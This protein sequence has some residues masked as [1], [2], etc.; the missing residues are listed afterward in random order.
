VTI[1]VGVS[2]EIVAVNLTMFVGVM[3]V[4]VVV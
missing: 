2:Q 3:T 1:V 4:V